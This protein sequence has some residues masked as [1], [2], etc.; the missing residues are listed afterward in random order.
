MKK[1]ISEK[2]KIFSSL[3][4]GFLVFSFILAPISQT[5]ILSTV[6]AVYI[7]SD[8]V[9]ETETALTTIEQTIATAAE[10]ATEFLTHTLWTKEFLLDTIAWGLVNIMLKEM[11]RSTT[12]W[13]KSGFKGSPAFVTDMEGFLLDIA[14][15]V[16]GNFIYGSALQGLCS[17]FKLNIQ[18]ALDIQYRATRGYQAMCR[19]SSV[20][21]NVDRFLAGDFLQGGWN[22]WYSV[23]LTPSNNPYGAMLQAQDAL[24][25]SIGSSQKNEADILGFGK[26]FLSVKQCIDDGAGFGE[27]CSIVTPGTAIENQLNMALGSPARRLEVADELNELVGA[28]AQQLAKEA[29]G[30]VGGLLGL[31]ESRNGQQNYFDRVSAENSQKSYEDPSLTP[32]KTDIDSETKYR[33]VQK[34]IIDIIT[35]ASTYKLRTYSTDEV[36]LDENGNDTRSAC[37]ATGELTTSLTNQ[38]RSAQKEVAS[39]TVLIATLT[40]F[41]TDYNLLTS[42]TTSASTTSRLILKYGASSVSE[43]QSK[44]M[45]QYLRYQ[46]SGVLHSTGEAIRL[47]LKTIKE[48]R[49]DIQSF[50]ASIDTAC[51]PTN[52]DGG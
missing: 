8:P 6:N 13:V 31:G 7:V 4:V 3:I 33:D 50:T 49:A 42:A 5:L 39:S 36:R 19:L 18:L 24:Y 34:T 41:S 1:I 15:K 26:G 51:R 27:Y 12:Q 28:L 16:A 14:D 20:I 10:V 17:P 21:K 38:L 52:S 43:A 35:D 47:E 2:R 32:G 45:D 46:T 11:I 22:G 48:I 30:G 29:L 23:T 44:L 25:A 9:V 40:V 37:R